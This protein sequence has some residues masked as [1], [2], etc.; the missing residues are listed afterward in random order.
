MS[1]SEYIGEEFSVKGDRYSVKNTKDLYNL[2]TIKIQKKPLC[3]A[4][5]GGMW[6]SKDSFSLEQNISLP[7]PFTTYYTTKILDRCYKG[8]LCRSLYY[9]KMPIVVIQFE[10]ECICIRF[11][12]II[13][14]NEF[15]MIPF[16]S[17]SEDKESYIISFYLF[18]EFYVM[19]KE[20]AWLGK[21]K[22]R[23]ESLDLRKGDIFNFSISIDKYNSWNEAIEKY[24]NKELCEDLIIES[25]CQIFEQG[26]KALFRSY[27]HLTGS[28]L[29][30]PWKKTPGFTFVNS[31]YSLL[32]YEAVRLHY[33]SEWFNKSGDNQFDIWCKGLR[34][35]FVDKRLYKTKLQRGAGIVWYNM[36]NLTKK[37]LE[38]FFYMDC[39]YSG[40]PGG[41]ATIAFHLLNYLKCCDDEKV[42]KLV[43][44]SLSYIVSTQN[45]N[46][47][48]P[49]AIRQEG[50][51]KFRSE[52]LS[53]YET[54]GGTAE[55]VRALLLGYSRFS[56]EAM[57]KTAMNGL[58]F[59]EDKYPICYNGLRDIGINEPEAFSAVSV[60][61]AFLDAYEHTH[62]KKYSDFAVLYAL[63][64]L[65][66]IY[67]Y[68][69]KNLK[70]KYNFHPISFSITP[71]LS[72][73]ES[74]WIVS[75][76]LRLYKKTNQRIWKNMAEMLYKQAVQWISKT[77]GLCEGIFPK[78]LD[79]LYCLP[80]E[81]TFATVELL[82]AST[83]FF[84]FEKERV[85]ADKK[86]F[87]DKIKI[88]IDDDIVVVFYEDEEVF[89]FSAAECKIISLKG[90]MLNKYGICFSFPEV[91]SWE[92]RVK[93]F[94]KKRL[95]GKYGKF[96][97][98]LSDVKYFLRGVYGPQLG[99]KIKI[100]S[101]GDHIKKWDVTVDGSYISG[102]CKTSLHKL[103]YTISFTKKKSGLLISFYPLVVEV[104]DQDLP[105]AHV[106][107]PVIGCELQRR[108]GNCL[109]FDDF[110][111]SGDFKNVIVQDDV[112][113]VDQSCATNWTHGGVFKGY[114]DIFLNHD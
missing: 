2:K 75:T 25:T 83:H 56:D 53:R 111:V 67:W 41:Q 76:F 6:Y 74:V 54:Q 42:E 106:L 71:R 14:C 92:N 109:V 33:F 108:N 64:A 15:E 89:R 11:D 66:W 36:T 26:K 73:Y 13:T 34:E 44:K 100:E 49:M 31:S 84:S 97:L 20:Y 77:G 16:I 10:D 85:N 8:V 110:F 30:L 39:G 98:S 72:P 52:D 80:M 47:S 94:I 7:Y 38:G 107:F 96:I 12:P 99:K 48:W 5:I 1:A 61:D 87:I 68:D 82:R 60:I 114:F 95:R 40:Y 45:S 65:T 46:G 17:L 91:Y 51:I 32:S 3:Y 104:L 62:E 112:T 86:P 63:Y 90:G 93:M 19:Q 4:F 43:E 22:K 24:V 37:G 105:L 9:V 57:R 113:A 23:K 27:D 79:G 101:L 78:F 35:L 59:L 103:K 55:S 28:F 88:E 70:I 18:N 50:V 81:Q 58:G 21:G 102:W 29:Q 69:T